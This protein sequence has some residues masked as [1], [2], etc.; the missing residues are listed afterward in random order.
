EVHFASNLSFDRRTNWFATADGDTTIEPTDAWIAAD[1]GGVGPAIAQYIHSPHGAPPVA[2]VSSDDGFT[3]TYSIVVPA[4]T[5]VE[6]A[7]FAILADD[8][9]SALAA[10]DRLID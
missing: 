6:L 4:K 10:V 3:W 2:L 7:Q 5:T 8:R 1:A 9:A